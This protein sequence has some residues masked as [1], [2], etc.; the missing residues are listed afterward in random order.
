MFELPFGEASQLGRESSWPF[1][2]ID[3]K[4]SHGDFPPVLK[5]KLTVGGKELEY[6][7]E[8]ISAHVIKRLKENAEHFLNRPVSKAV[9][10]VP[11]N[12][13][14]HQKEATKVAAQIAGFQLRDILIQN[15]PTAAAVAY[16]LENI[17][18]IISISEQ[19]PGSMIT[20]HVFL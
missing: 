18:S 11:A 12:F 6:F 9:I 13:K 3:K 5:V 7:P 8:E 16:G 20:S 10:C 15:E 2:V 14:M 1:Q 19:T 17:V 4:L